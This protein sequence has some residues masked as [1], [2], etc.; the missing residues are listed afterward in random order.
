M[1]NI[2]SELGCMDSLSHSLVGKIVR[3]KKNSKGTW[4]NN[5]TDKETLWG[6]VVAVWKREDDHLMLAVRVQNGEMGEFF[7]TDLALGMPG[8]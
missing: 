1:A 3:P 6:T 2:G 7:L 8:D 5:F 4:K